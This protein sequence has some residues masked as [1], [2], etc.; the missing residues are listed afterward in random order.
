[1]NY[2]SF[3]ISKYRAI[4]ELEVKL[5][6]KLIPLVGINECGKTTI[7][8]A[9]YSFDYSNDAEYEGRHINSIRNLYDTVDHDSVITAKI[10]LKRKDIIDEVKTIKEEIASGDIKLLA[11]DE[12]F[13]CELDTLI[14]ELSPIEKE[15]QIEISRNIAKKTYSTNWNHNGVLNSSTINHKFCEHIVASMPYIL[16]NDDFA[17][18]PPSEIPIPAAKPKSLTGWLAIYERLFIMT[19]PGYSLFSLIT[20]TDQRRRDSVLSDVESK[21]NSTLSAAWKSFS[22]DKSAALDISLKIKNAPEKALQISIVEKL[23]GKNRYFDVLDRSKGFVWHYNFIMKTQFNPKVIGKIEDTVFLLDEPG[24]YL[25]S[26]AQDKLCTKL[27]EISKKYGIVIYCTHSHHL[28]NPIIIPLKDVLIVEKGKRKKI[29]STIPLPIYKTKS[30]KNTALQPIYEALQIPIYEIFSDASTLVL[31]EGINDKYSIE[32]FTA[33]PDNYKILPG[34]SADSILKNIQ[35]ML[36]YDKKFIALWDND[37]EGQQIKKKAANLFH[38][39]DKYLKTLPLEGRTK[40]RMEE[41]FSEKDISLMARVLEMPSES[42]YDVLL[43]SVFFSTKKLKKEV[44]DGLTDETKKS[45]SIL[46]KMLFS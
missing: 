2:I 27:S 29:I 25:H 42:N 6:T 21:L 12:A 16:Y 43:P 5:D 23:E 33:V 3:T 35:Y 13:S 37:G 24:S 30:E 20:E 17:D 4:D 40:R 34:T 39:D 10:A 41:M 32:L 18:R 31:V 36:T 15:I 38:V 1:M 9:I 7:L 26:S 22:A 19:N 28:L 46:S 14:K 11:T 45:F 44:F 8:Q